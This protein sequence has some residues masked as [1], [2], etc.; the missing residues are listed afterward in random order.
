MLQGSTVFADLTCI[1]NDDV[2]KEVPASAQTI[3]ET[4][5]AC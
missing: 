3:F 5:A 1:P 4:T 2:F